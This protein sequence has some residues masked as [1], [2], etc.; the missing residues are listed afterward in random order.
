MSRKLLVLD[1]VLV[2][3]VVYAGFQLRQ[4]VAGRQGARGGDAADFHEGAGGAPVFTPLPAEAPVVAAGYVDIAQK[5]L[6][7]KSR[8]PTVVVDVPPPP[9]PKPMPPLPVYHGLMNL[10]GL[11]ALLSVTQR[12]A[13]AGHSSGGDHRPIQ[14]GGRQ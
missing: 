9:P 1:V 12:R 7:D 11:T 8:N 6:F 10:G 3:I 14:A 2:A 5:I 13:A 4:G